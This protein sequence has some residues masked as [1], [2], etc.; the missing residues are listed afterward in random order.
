MRT[1][2]AAA[3]LL[4]SLAWGGDGTTRIEIGPQGPE[5]LIVC[6][7]ERFPLTVEKDAAVATAQDEYKRWVS[8][9]LRD[10]IN[11]GRRERRD[12]RFVLN[13][14]PGGAIVWSTWPEQDFQAMCPARCAPAKRAAKARKAR[15]RSAIATK[16][17]R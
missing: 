3:L 4:T 15:R 14:T 7:G 10:V 9:P 16:E 12:G 13:C 17:N 11:Q 6:S 8:S 1:T 5:V 2:I